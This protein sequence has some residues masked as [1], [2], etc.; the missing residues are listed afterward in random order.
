MVAHTPTF[1][2]HTW[3][4]PLPPIQIHLL[5]VAFS[6]MGLL[7]TKQVLAAGSG[8]SALISNATHQRK[9]EKTT[10]NSLVTV[11]KIHQYYNRVI[12]K[13]DDPFFDDEDPDK[14]A[15]NFCMFMLN[16]L[17]GAKALASS[18]KESHL[19]AMKSFFV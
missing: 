16:A 19:K 17:D 7:Q 9:L 4:L 1:H 2:P 13:E 14:V 6:L 11:L 12:R 5:P 10:A 3:H 15:G 18:T 8:I